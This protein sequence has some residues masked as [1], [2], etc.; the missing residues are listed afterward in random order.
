[1]RGSGVL[2]QSLETPRRTTIALVKAAN[3]ITMA[4]S[5]INIPVR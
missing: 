5:P 4:A 1:M 3:N 2:T